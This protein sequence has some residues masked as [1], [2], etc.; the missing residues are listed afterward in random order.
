AFNRIAAVLSE[1]AGKVFRFKEQEQLHEDIIDAGLAKIYQGHLDVAESIARDYGVE[2]ETTLLDGKPYEVI[3]KQVANINP[4]LL[5]MGKLGIHADDD[6]D[7]GGNAENLLRNVDCAVLLSQR[8]HQ[9]RMDVVADATTSWT[10]QAEE[11]ML[12]VP[13][14]ARGMARMG[15]LRYAQEMGHTVVTEKIVAEATRDLCPVVHGEDDDASSVA[16]ANNPS[17][18]GRDAQFNPDWSEQA[19]LIAASIEDESLRSNLKM[20]AEKRARQDSSPTVEPAHILA[21]MDVKAQSTGEK[22]KCPMGFGSETEEVHSSLPW[23]ADAEQRLERVPAGFMRDLTR[24]RVE[25]YCR[26]EGAL[27]VTDQLMG[28]KYQDWAEGSARQTMKM[29]WSERALEKIERIPEF[30][31][32]M[33]IKEVERCAADLGVDEITPDVLSRSSSNWSDTGRF[34]SEQ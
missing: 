4:S 30:V 26:S 3:G 21:L 8:E 13:S 2:I 14:F 31:Q 29:P 9:P 12:K 16:D 7:I 22:G 6:L 19:E 32:G 23:T 25:Q 20:R 28:E 24:K 18:S 34:H 5:V 27:E 33:V 15:V 1:E 17:S 11:R 10:H